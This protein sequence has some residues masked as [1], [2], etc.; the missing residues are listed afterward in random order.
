VQSKEVL[1]YA[2]L[3]WVSWINHDR[4]FEPLGYIPPA[5]AEANYYQQFATRATAVVV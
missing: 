3:E 4:P 1:E 5:E 2:A